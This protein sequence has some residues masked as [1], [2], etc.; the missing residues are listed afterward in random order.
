MVICPIRALAIES[1][2]KLLQRVLDKMLNGSGQPLDSQHLWRLAASL[3]RFSQW[4]I[5]IFW[6][7]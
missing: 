3:C 7:V 6:D 2:N 1:A 5:H 4:L